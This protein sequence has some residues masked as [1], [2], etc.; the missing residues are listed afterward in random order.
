[1]PKHT[2]KLLLVAALCWVVPASA[3]QLPVVA[4]Q[5]KE[6]PGCPLARAKLLAQT[7]ASQSKARTTTVI[8]VSRDD[9][10]GE[11]PRFGASRAFQP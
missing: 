1:M 11:G 8:F 5:L 2:R 6:W 4:G 7:K 9:A 10:I 3:S